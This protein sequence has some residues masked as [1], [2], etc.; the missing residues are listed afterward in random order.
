M[1][2]AQ[3]ILEKN[4]TLSGVL[5]FTA[6]MTVQLVTL[7]L[8]NQAGSG[9]LETDQLELVY[10]FAQFAVIAG[11]LIHAAVCGRLSG[12][13]SRVGVIG[14]ALGVSAVGAGIMLF[15]GAGS[16]FYLAA[17]G[18]TVLCLGFVLGAVYLRLS[19]LIACG[20]RAGAC[21]GIGYAVAVALQYLFQLQQTVK[22]VL[23]ILLIA[24]FAVLMC[25]LTSRGE[26]AVPEAESSDP[27]T[28]RSKLILGAVITF[29]MLVFTTY[30]NSYIHHLQ[31]ASG[32]TE[33]NVYSWP[34]LLMIP[35]MLVFGFIGELRK[36]RFLPISVLCLVMLSLLNTAVLGQETYLLNMCLFYISLTAVIA[37]YHLTFLRL[38][39]RTKRPALWAAMGRM[40]DSVS[41]IIAFGM[42]YSEFSTVTVLVIDIAALAVTVIAMAVNGDLALRAPQPIRII[43]TVAVPVAAPAVDPFPIMQE[44]YELTPGEMKVLRELVL[45]DDKQ[46]IIAERLEISV[47]TLKHH[48]TSIYKKTDTKSRTAL[49]KLTDSKR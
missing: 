26:A 1:K 49:S 33:Y 2:K 37:Y 24:A 5:L 31:I 15:S 45:T 35:A 3:I 44:D 14:A 25:L 18:V 12:G 16:L 39:P 28:P 30:Y 17:T 40:L 9:Y 29:A 48:I 34:R 19:S 42:R 20:A 7:R 22:P 47:S 23:A 46:E 21:V 41:V 43:E 27:A 38:A 11:F 10:L 8:A 6:F 32:Y 13:R 4:K 36:G